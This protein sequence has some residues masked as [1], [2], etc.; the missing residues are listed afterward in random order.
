M[1][2]LD[3]RIFDD[4]DLGPLRRKR[5]CGSKPR[6]RAAPLEVGAVGCIINVA[7]DEFDKKDGV[8]IVGFGIRGS[9]LP[10]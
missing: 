10:C 6:G 4:R 3:R 1:V 5:R 2:L 9:E 7:V 8:C